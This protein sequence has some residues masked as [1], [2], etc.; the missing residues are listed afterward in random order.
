MERIAVIRPGALGDTILT[1]PA[2]AALREAFAGAKLTFAG[3]AAVLTLLAS[4]HYADAVLSSD[5]P[6]LMPLFV[7]L[8][9]PSP[10]LMA[11]FGDLD[12]AVL[13]LRDS[14]TV[15]ENLRQMGARAVIAA[16]SR[17][18]QG[19]LQHAG[20]YLLATLAPVLAGRVGRRAAAHAHL[21]PGAEQRAFANRFWRQ[22]G[23]AGRAVVAI[24]P[25]SG[26]RCKCWPAARFAALADLL[27]GRGI[28][29][30]LVAGPADDAVAGAFTAALRSAQPIPVAGLPVPELAAVLAQ[31]TAFVG[32][33]SGVSHLAAALG[34]P[35]V[36]IYGP[37]DPLVWGVRGERVML[38]RDDTL[39]GVTV[40]EVARAVALVSPDQSC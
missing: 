15:A 33:D 27:A 37:T 3:N 10:Q 30:M 4:G 18:P 29:T 22:H 28:A 20:D 40:Q 7:P 12:L 35:T 17:P 9:Q 38:V 34:V 23:L 39:E 36:A 13:W 32:N 6:A 16:P 26:G 31:C 8:E 1:L 19:S 14:A 11:H 2:L 24:H 5:D 25:G 21:S